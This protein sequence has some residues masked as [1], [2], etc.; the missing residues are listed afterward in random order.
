MPLK[1]TFDRLDRNDIRPQI[2]QE[3][4]AQWAHQEVIETND[5]YSIQLHLALLSFSTFRSTRQ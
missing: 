5:A 1:C 4:N 3:L 2:G